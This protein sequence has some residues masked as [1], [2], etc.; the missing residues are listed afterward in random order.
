MIKIAGTGRYVPDFV[1]ENSDFTTI[2]DT[3]DEWIRTRTGIERRHVSLDEPAWQMA[4]RASVRALAAAGK[5]PAEIDMIVAATVTPD[6]DFPALACFVQREIGAKG[7][8]AL[9]IRVACAG[10]TYGLDM[11]A[12]YIATGKVKTAL[13]IGVDRLTQLTN[14][15]DRATCVL[16]GD[17]AGAMVVEQGGGM[18]GSY[19]ECNP[20]GIEYLYSKHTRKKIPFGPQDIDDRPAWFEPAFYNNIYM[21]GREV[22]KFASTMMPHA[23]RMACE[24][25]GIAPEELDLIVPHQANR[26]IIESAMKH[27]KL[28]MEKTYVNIQEY[29]N[30]SSGT[31]PVAL[32]ECIR[33]GKIRRGDKI[34]IVGFGGGLALGA[35]VFEY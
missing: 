1:V 30:A 12:R 16:F 13:V 4:A 20:D 14:Y 23:V 9:D 15:E 33:D 8:F 3:S 10:V 19:L 29:G 7:A 5:D 32:D 21:H 11:A 18:F 22:Y 35:N 31:I 2:V 27:L 28:P 25:A 6:Y 34:C 26:R 17:L 24:D